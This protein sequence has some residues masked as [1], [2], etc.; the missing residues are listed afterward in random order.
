MNYKKN[1]EMWEKDWKSDSSFMQ[2]IESD[3]KITVR[4]KEDIQ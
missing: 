4:R 3:L 2:K 1:P